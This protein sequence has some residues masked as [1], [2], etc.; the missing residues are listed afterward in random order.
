MYGV[1]RAADESPVFK[2]MRAPTTKQLHPRV[3]NLLIILANVQL[4]YDNVLSAINW[5]KA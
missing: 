3:N 5:G 1:Y 2:P 4:G